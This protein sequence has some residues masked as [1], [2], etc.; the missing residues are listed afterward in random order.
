MLTSYTI[1]VRKEGFHVTARYGKHAR[2]ETTTKTF[3]WAIILLEQWHTEDKEED[4][5]KLKDKYGKDYAFFIP[6]LKKGE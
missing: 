5:E 6:E 3:H 4:V 2:Y 1:E